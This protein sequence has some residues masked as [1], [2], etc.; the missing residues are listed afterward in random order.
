MDWHLWKMVPT[1]QMDWY[2]WKMV[3]TVEMER[4]STQLCKRKS[5]PAC[6]QITQQYD[7]KLVILFSFAR[8]NLLLHAPFNLCAK[9]TLVFRL[10]HMCHA[11]LCNLSCIHCWVYVDQSYISL[12]SPIRATLYQAYWFHVKTVFTA[13]THQKYISK[14]YPLL[15]CCFVFCNCIILIINEQ[16]NDRT[17][18][19]NFA[20]LHKGQVSVN[21]CHLS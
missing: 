12:D 18:T 5:T 1:V 9:F 7:H 14:Q 8:H 21:H 4:E 13:S 15:F 2:L 10:T 6:L 11:T 20:H 19:Y 17:P 3:P 16:V